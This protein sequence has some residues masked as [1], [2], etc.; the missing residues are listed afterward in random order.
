MDF[1]TLTGTNPVNQ[2][3]NLASQ[4]TSTLSDTNSPEY[5]FLDWL[6][7]V[8]GFN[9]YKNLFDTETN[10][11]GFGNIMWRDPK[12]GFSWVDLFNR[13]RLGKATS[14][15]TGSSDVDIPDE[16][17]DYFKQGID[18]FNENINRQY[19]YNALESAKQREWLELMSNTQYQ[20]AV[21]DLKEAGINPLLAFQGGFQPASVSGGATASGSLGNSNSLFGSLLSGILGDKKLTMQ[22]LTALAGIFRI[23]FLNK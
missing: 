3:T 2:N 10:Y 11:K 14:D 15:L 1:P 18:M 19:E 20:R 4:D 22:L 9:F 6:S 17:L 23:F 8:S 21:A 12:T 13:S 5:T 16:L 7:S